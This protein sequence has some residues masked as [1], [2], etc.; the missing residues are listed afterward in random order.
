M[1]SKCAGTNMKSPW[2]GFDVLFEAFSVVDPDVPFQHIRRSLG[3]AVIVRRAHGVRHA[4]YMAEP[5]LLCPCGVAVNAGLADHAGGSGRW[6]LAMPRREP[7]SA[8]CPLCKYSFR[9]PS[10]DRHLE[11]QVDLPSHNTAALT[12]GARS[13]QLLRLTHSGRKQHP[14][15]QSDLQSLRNGSPPARG[16]LV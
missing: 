11:C 15:N 3:L 1:W 7:P 2:S 16:S 9:L 12:E 5:D 10:M 4:F 6:C 13:E 8:L 14:G